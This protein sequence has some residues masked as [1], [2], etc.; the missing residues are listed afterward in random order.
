LQDFSL[1]DDA[2]VFEMNGGKIE[3]VEG[4]EYNIKV[5]TPLDLEI[6]KIN[7]EKL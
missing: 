1:T 6:V 5:T 7:Y 4:E 3:V 2:S